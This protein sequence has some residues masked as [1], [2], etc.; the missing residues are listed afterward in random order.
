MLV[1]ISAIEEWKREDREIALSHCRKRNMRERKK[2][3]G[4]V[5]CG[6]NERMKKSKSVAE[7]R[8]RLMQWKGKGAP[9]D[10]VELFFPLTRWRL[11]LRAECR[12]SFSRACASTQGRCQADSRPLP[13]LLDPTTL[14]QLQGKA[15]IGR[16]KET[17]PEL[18]RV[19]QRQSLMNH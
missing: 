4:E 2:G 10:V 9:R 11:A 19:H 15:T 6:G 8:T 3:D 7:G 1:T 17:N 18:C 13:T 12:R 5:K 16:A 14:P